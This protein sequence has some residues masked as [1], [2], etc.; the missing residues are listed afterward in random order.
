MTVFDS[1]RSGRNRFA[2]GLGSV[3]SYQ[4]AG[5]P[6]MTGSGTDGLGSGTEHKIEFPTITKSILVVN[7]DAGDCDVR[8]HFVS[9]DAPGD[10][11][12]GFHYFTLDSD[13]DS[14]SFNIKCKEIYVSAVGCDSTYELVAELTGI[15]TTEMFPL[16]GSGLTD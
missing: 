5:V 2:V 7:K 3:G 14:V 10:V 11:Y 16:T 4:V 8:V 6:F 13:T 1:A 9:K 12:G 15:A